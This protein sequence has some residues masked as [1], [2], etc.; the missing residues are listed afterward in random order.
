MRL[1][2]FGML[3]VTSWILSGGVAVKLFDWMV[4]PQVPKQPRWLEVTPEEIK[5][6]EKLY[7]ERLRLCLAAGPVA[8]LGVFVTAWAI[9]IAKS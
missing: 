2:E 6:K 4:L 5:R 3:F 1:L 9:K 8:I 7:K